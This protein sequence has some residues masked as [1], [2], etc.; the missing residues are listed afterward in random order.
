MRGEGGTKICV[1][2]PV[3]RVAFEIYDMRVSDE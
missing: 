3:S 1:G 2:C